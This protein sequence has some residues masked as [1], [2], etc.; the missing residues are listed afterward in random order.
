MAFPLAALAYS[1]ARNTCRS[2]LKE[3]GGFFPLTTIS[4]KDSF[5]GKLS[6]ALEVIAHVNKSK[7]NFSFGIAQN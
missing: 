7:K 4:V 3:T 6:W 1:A 5:L 2:I